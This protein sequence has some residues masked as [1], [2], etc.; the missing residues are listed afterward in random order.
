MSIET[1]IPVPANPALANTD[2]PWY[3]TGDQGEKDGGGVIGDLYFDQD[4]TLFIET[5]PV[6]GTLRVMNNGGAGQVVAAN[7]PTEVRV[8]F[9]GG[10]TKLRLRTSGTAPTVWHVNGRVVEAID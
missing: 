8:R 2:V 3:D 7:T 10:R 4:V 9:N 5:A 6:A 1:F